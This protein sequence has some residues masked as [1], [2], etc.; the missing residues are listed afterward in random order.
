ME[1][2]LA[3]WQTLNA[4]LAATVLEEEVRLC[5]RG[6]E[7]RQERRRSVQNSRIFRPRIRALLRR[8]A[9]PRNTRSGALHFRDRTANPVHL[10]FQRPGGERSPRSY[11]HDRAH[12]EHEVRGT[13]PAAAK[14][15]AAGSPPQR[16][17]TLGILASRGFHAWDTRELVRTRC[18]VDDSRPRPG[19][20]WITAPRPLLV[21]P[22]SAR[23]S[24]VRTTR[25]RRV[26][27]TRERPVSCRAGAR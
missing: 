10:V 1:P 22:D 16:A 25:R 18:R 12:L 15:S 21:G 23:S 14:P 27:P 20:A 26:L 2:R 11:I 3:N 17:A 6:P 8:V 9:P 13:L 5:L 24:F 19:K 7:R 4:E